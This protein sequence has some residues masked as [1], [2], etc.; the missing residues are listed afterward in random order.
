MISHCGRDKVLGAHGWVLQD[1]QNPSFPAL[2]HSQVASHSEE[3]F[4]YTRASIIPSS[5]ASPKNVH[6]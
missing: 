2:H 1:Q 5:I 3:P 4:S 6:D